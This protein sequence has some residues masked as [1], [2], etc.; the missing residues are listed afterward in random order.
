MGEFKSFGDRTPRPP[1]WS[2]R[3]RD[4]DRTDADD[5]YVEV[6]RASDDFWLN[7]VQA[8]EWVIPDTDEFWQ[9]WRQEVRWAEGHDFEYPRNDC[10][11]SIGLDEIYSGVKITLIEHALDLCSDETAHD[12][13]D[14]VND[15]ARRHRVAIRLEG[16]RFVP[17]TS[18]HV[19]KEVVQP[20]LALLREERFEGI[21]GLYRKAFDRA[22]SGDPAGAITAATSAVEE[23]FRLGL[24]TTTSI[25]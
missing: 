3:Q 20:A 6:K 13:A 2:E 5:I 24:Q 17:V 18:E 4:E 1:T 7:L 23:M 19:H 10:L 21:D 8:V 22:L 12:F 25:P 11:A 9:Q 15:G 16:R 14:L